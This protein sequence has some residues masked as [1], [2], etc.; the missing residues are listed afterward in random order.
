MWRA[1]TG[2][3]GSFYSMRNGE[4]LTRGHDGVAWR[5]REGVDELD[6]VALPECRP[7][8]S[9]ATT[10]SSIAGDGRLVRGTR[11]PDDELI[12]LFECSELGQFERDDCEVLVP[13]GCPGDVGPGSIGSRGN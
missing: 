6:V 12:E 2:S 5:W 9:P 1:D 11:E 3:V 4:H 7:P 13:I 10:S 8:I